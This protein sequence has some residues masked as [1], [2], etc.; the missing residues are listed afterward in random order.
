MP[1]AYVL[2]I[3]L[4]PPPHT[5]NYGARKCSEGLHDDPRFG[6]WVPQILHGRQVRTGGAAAARVQG[7]DRQARL[8]APSPIRVRRGRRGRRAGWLARGRHA[9][10]PTPRV[11]GCCTGLAWVLPRQRQCVAWVL[12]S[13]A[14]SDA[15]HMHA[16]LTHAHA[17]ACVCVCVRVPAVI[18]ALGAL[19]RGDGGSSLALPITPSLPVPGPHG[20][21]SGSR[22]PRAVDRARP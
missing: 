6:P 15:H 1:G 10:P 9:A 5:R 4:P 16:P 11:P 13:S 3:F 19:R 22:Y 7:L 21:P 20:R 18:D 14:P 8:P 2:R 17:R 12:Q